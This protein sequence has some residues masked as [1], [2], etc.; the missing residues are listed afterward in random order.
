LILRF[1]LLPVVVDCPLLLYVAVCVVVCYVV[2]LVY[3]HF[4]A[5][6]V[7]TLLYVATVG[8][9]LLPLLLF[10]C[11]LFA[12][13]LRLRVRCCYV[14]FYVGCTLPVT[15][16]LDCVALRCRWLRLRVVPR[17]RLICYVWLVTRCCWIVT[18]AFTVVDLR[19]LLHTLRCVA[20]DL[21]RW[22]LFI[23]VYV[24][25]YHVTFVVAVTLLLLPGRCYPF[26]LPLH[27]PR[28]PVTFT[29]TLPDLVICCCRWLPG[30]RLPS[31]HT[32]YVAL[33]YVAGLI[34][35]G[36]PRLIYRLP[37]GYGCC[38]CTRCPVRC[39]VAF[40]LRCVV[41]LLVVTLFIAG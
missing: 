12:L 16:L 11:D 1:A 39:Y 8:Y 2:A 32:R 3:A 23:Y 28:S 7:A 18:F 35:V 37:V 4:T 14:V 19:A 41:T 20:V 36:C 40:T 22:L 15:L 5:R 38:C 17:L 34:C 21:L 6:C 30:L 13:R 33:G 10:G 27:T 9:A 29:F 25:V 31:L 26:T 24:Y